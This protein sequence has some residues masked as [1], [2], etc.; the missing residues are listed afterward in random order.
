MDAAT[1]ATSIEEHLRAALNTA[2]HDEVKYRLR[3]S[4]Q[5]LHVDD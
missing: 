5:K 3:E 2:E 4:I 1:D